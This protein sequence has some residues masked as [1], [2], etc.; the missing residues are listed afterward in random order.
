VEE[1]TVT[2]RNIGGMNG[3]IEFAWGTQAA[4]AN[5]TARIAR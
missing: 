4:A 2:V 1:L 5:F 3:A